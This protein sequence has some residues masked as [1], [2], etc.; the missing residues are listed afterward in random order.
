MRGSFISVAMSVLISSRN[1]SFT[2]SVLR[3]TPYLH[4]PPR[5]SAIGHQP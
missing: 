1:N 5:P 3:D 2:R 4:A